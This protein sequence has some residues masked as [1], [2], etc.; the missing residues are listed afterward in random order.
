M[1]R[2][3][4]A[5]LRR[6]R[7]GARR[8]LLRIYTPTSAW[9]NMRRRDAWFVNLSLSS[10]VFTS[11]NALIFW[12]LHSIPNGLVVVIAVVSPSTFS[13]SATSTQRKW[14]LTIR[15]SVF[16]RA[17]S[18][19]PSQRVCS[20]C[21]PCMRIFLALLCLFALLCQDPTPRPLS[22]HLPILSM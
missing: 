13:R 10:I 8:M 15:L 7:T 3:H 12:A 20:T 9:I 14:L 18:P 17:T 16:L 19:L 22:S 21:L 2:V 6:Q 11:G 1:S 4:G 5:N